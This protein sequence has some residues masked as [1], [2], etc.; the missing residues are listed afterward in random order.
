IA[1]TTLLSGIVIYSM[2]KS[3]DSSITSLEKAFKRIY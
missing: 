1:S 2:A 3:I